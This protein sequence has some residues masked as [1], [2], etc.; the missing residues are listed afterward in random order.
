MSWRLAIHAAVAAS[1]AVVG[2][3]GAVPQPS[4]VPQPGAFIR[5]TPGAVD[6]AVNG[7][8]S[9]VEAIIAA[10]TDAPRDACR[11]GDGADTLQ[12]AGRFVLTEVPAGSSSRTGLP[13]VTSGLTIVDAKIS[14]T[15]DAPAFRILQVANGGALT[16]LNGSISGG[17]AV[18]CPD[19]GAAICAGGILNLGTLTLVDSR[20]FENTAAGS[21]SIVGGAGIVNGGTASFINSIVRDNL[22][23]GDTAA[24]GGGITNNTGASLSLVNSAL[25]GNSSVG[26]TG[27]VA[28]GGGL[29]NFGTASLTTS[30][31]Q[32]NAVSAPGGTATGGGIYQ[33][34]AVTTLRLTRVNGNEPNDCQP[35]I[36]AICG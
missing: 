14:R 2:L 21:G 31:V 18:D 33:E 32:H 7:N 27:G 8:C 22:A 25:R 26:P 13:T 19:G 3:T 36:A 30:R 17:S 5:V 28:V 12:A 6:D 24:V 1:V 11:A 4:A 16:M 35:A 20:V 15:T 10:N 23:A 34:N 9:L 29:A